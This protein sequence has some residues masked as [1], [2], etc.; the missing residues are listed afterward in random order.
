[1]RPIPTPAPSHVGATFMATWTKAPMKK[2]VMRK[3]NCSLMVLRPTS[4]ALAIAFPRP[5]AEI[6]EKADR[7]DILDKHRKNGVSW[8]RIIGYPKQ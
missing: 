3:I 4:I 6:F 7:Q 8:Q 1:V 2:P 5:V